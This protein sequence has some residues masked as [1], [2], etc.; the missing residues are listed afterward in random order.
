[1]LKNNNA[2]FSPLI[3]AQAGIFVNDLVNTNKLIYP[4]FFKNLVQLLLL[5]ESLVPFN[6]I[7][8]VLLEYIKNKSEVD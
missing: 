2:V 5:W 7:K 6:F 3:S 4:G 1:M 8:I